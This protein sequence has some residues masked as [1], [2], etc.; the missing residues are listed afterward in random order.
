[1][2]GSGV[3][4]INEI[5]ARLSDDYHISHCIIYSDIKSF[6]ENMKEEGLLVESE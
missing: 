5:C 1:M 4:D 3:H 2:I 6:V